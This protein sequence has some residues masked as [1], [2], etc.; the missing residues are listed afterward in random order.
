MSRSDFMKHQLLAVTFWG[1]GRHRESANEYWAAYLTLSDPTCEWRYHIL[2]GYTSILR[3]SS[4]EANEDDFKNMRKVFDDKHEPRLFRLEAGYTLGVLHYSRTERHE[5]EDA[6]H[7]AIRIGKK[8]PKKARDEKMEKKNMVILTGSGSE[9]KRS[10]KELME[11]VLKDCQTNLNELN[12]AT[13][14]PVG[15]TFGPDATKRTHLMPIGRGG[16]SLTEDEINNLMD[17]GGIHCDHCKRKDAKLLKCA[18]CNREFYCSKEC[19]RKQWKENEHKVY[20]R[21]EGQFEPGDLVQIARL[22][23]RPE[24]NY[25]IMRLIGPDAVAEGRY[26][27]RIEGGVKGDPYFSISAENL[28]QMRPYDCR[29]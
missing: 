19:Q 4:F 27:V 9:Q 21:K 20:C 15:T 24:L 3:G 17:V 22:K 8:K 18:R 29:K 7:E 25:N 5:C 10:M 26:R 14:G 11:G 6:Y 1:Q 16:T 23:N 13:R 12:A 2:H 28:N